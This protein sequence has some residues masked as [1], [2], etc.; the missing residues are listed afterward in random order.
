[1]NEL[2]LVNTN[3]LSNKEL[4]KELTSISRSL[5]G[6]AGSEWKIA[7]S[8][9]NIMGKELY[10]DDFKTDKAFAAV[11][12]VSRASLSRMHRAVDLLDGVVVEGVKLLM[13][14]TVNKVSEMVAIPVEE[15]P[16]FLY[17]Y[18]INSNSTVREIREAVAC[19]KDD[20][21]EKTTFKEAHKQE[22]EQEQ[23]NGYEPE[24][25]NITIPV[26]IV[27]D[28]VKYADLMVTEEDICAILKVL[29]ER[30]R[31]NIE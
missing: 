3:E 20:N 18:G 8:V 14:Y 4:A 16:A 28:A 15:I 7:K 5:T 31:I 22:Q 9:H 23:E 2:K 6:I 10:K 24:L 26:D 21:E 12:G 19:W 17:G 13:D 29:K 30:G 25:F 1:M 11:I 27:D